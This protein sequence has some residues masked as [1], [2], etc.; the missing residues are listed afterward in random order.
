MEER[1]AWFRENL[2]NFKHHWTDS[3]EGLGNA[4]HYGGIP[5]SAISRISIY[6][7]RSNPSITMM[8]SDPM[9]SIMNYQI[10][11]G[12][13]YRALTSWFMGDPVDV[14]DIDPTWKLLQM[15]GD[16]SE[17]MENHMKEFGKA[18]KNRSGLEVIDNPQFDPDCE[19]W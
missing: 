12:T 17:M 19:G 11:G 2:A 3:L 18:L 9:I 10:L 6:D 4:A 5:A 7:P 16:M 1:T 13:K 15:S 8:V 14:G